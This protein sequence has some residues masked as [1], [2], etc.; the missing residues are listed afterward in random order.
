MVGDFGWNDVGS[1]DALW[2][3]QKKDRDGISATGQCIAVNSKASLVYSPEKIVA[4]I[5]VQDLIVV[6]TKDALLICRRGSSQ[7]VR[8]VTEILKNRRMTDYL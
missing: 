3:I 6:E 8:K 4:L 2:D 1:W 7:H 5:D